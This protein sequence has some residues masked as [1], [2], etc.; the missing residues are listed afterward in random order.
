MLF[1]R[2]VIICKLR[3]DLYCLDQ[4]EALQM[5]FGK[6]ERVMRSLFVKRLYLYP[7][8]HE[9]VIASFE[10]RTSRDVGDSRQ[11]L[12]ERLTLQPEVVELSISLTS[13]MKE[14]QVQ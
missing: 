5:E 13:D 10:G 7:R 1:V 14:V 3:L 4:P 6:V 8:F 2:V 12:D 9:T 11:Q